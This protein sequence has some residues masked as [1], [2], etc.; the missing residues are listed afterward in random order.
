MRVQAQ[1]RV[2]RILA[3]KSLPRPPL[4]E[5]CMAASQACSRLQKQNSRPRYTDMDHKAASNSYE[6]LTALM[7]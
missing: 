6:A 2:Q 1:A 7:N 3:L 4:L 5:C